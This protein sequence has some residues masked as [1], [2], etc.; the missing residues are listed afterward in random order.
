MAEE[1]GLILPL[2]DFV[3]RTA[4]NTLLRL[5]ARYPREQ[6][7]AM[8]VNISARQLQQPLFVENVLTAITESGILPDSVVLELTESILLEDTAHIVKLESLRRHGIRIAVDDFGTGYSSLSYLRSLPVDTL[9]IAKPFVDD[10]GAEQGNGDFARAIVGLGAALRLSLIAEGIEQATQ[11]SQL[12]ELGCTLGQGFYLSHPVGAEEIEA[13]LQRGGID[14]SI[15]DV[16]GDSRLEQVI[17]LRV[18]R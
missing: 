11:V 3:L 6:P 13:L 4:C 1:S 12:R 17:P 5:H 14:R 9:K 18:H 15:L 2:G 16:D 10:L 8:A 7:L